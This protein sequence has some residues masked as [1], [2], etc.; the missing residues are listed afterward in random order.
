MAAFSNASEAF[1]DERTSP[2]AYRNQGINRQA[3]GEQQ[4]GAGMNG[5]MF[6]A[7]TAAPNMRY[8]TMRDGFG[9][10]MQGGGVGN[11]HFPY[12]AS[13]AQTWSAGAPGQGPF[14]NGMGNLGQ[15]A[16][17]GPSRSIKPS[18]G[19]VGVSQVSLQEVYS[20]RDLITNL[21]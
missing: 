18:R 16:N 7:D 4:Y 19:R 14:G 15:N 9:G 5:Q 12:D 3:G 17:F 20:M 21:P 11:V 8:E 10:P 1:Y 13:A 2:R 6:G